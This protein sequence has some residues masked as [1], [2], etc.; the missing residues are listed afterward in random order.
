MVIRWREAMRRAIIA[1]MMRAT[2]GLA[3]LPVLVPVLALVLVLVL[4]FASTARAGD[5]EGIPWFRETVALDGA[6]IFAFLDTDVEIRGTDIDLES[7][8]DLNDFAVLPSAG[9]RWRFSDNKKHRIEAGYFSILR[10]AAVT[11]QREITLP[12]GSTI[13]IGARAET[14]LDLHVAS[15]TYGYSF[16]HRPTL[17]LGIILG[18]DFIVADSEVRGSLSGPSNVLSDDLLGEHFD[19]PFP[20]AGLYFDWAFLER[21]AL[22]SRFQYFGVKVG[23][24]SGELFRGGFQLE[25]RTTKHLHLFAGYEALGANIDLNSKSVGDLSLVYHGPRAGVRILF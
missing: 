14:D 24:I 7:D 16:L 9:L 25:H 10:S 8:L 12:D 22:L 19:V 20:T 15:L 23:G 4:G 2:S 18:L 1:S 11:V 17:E 13:P 3:A 5:D 21:L 6:A